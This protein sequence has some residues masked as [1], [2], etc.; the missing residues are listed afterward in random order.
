MEPGLP[1]GVDQE[2]EEVVEAVVE[3]GWEGA[4]WEGRDPEQAPVGAVF[5]PIAAQVSPTRW[6]HLATT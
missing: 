1:E 2:Q 5:V 4:G 6:G 3:A